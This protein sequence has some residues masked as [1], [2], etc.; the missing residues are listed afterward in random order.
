MEGDE[1]SR[2]KLLLN[3]EV[4]QGGTDLLVIAVLTRIDM[5][6]VF[7]TMN[8]CA[9]DGIGRLRQY[10]ERMWHA[11]RYR[12]LGGKGVSLGETQW[13]MCSQWDS[14]NE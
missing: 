7:A 9:L 12:R 1:T 11:L 10:L 13:P 6:K 2:C 8:Q 5:Y 3:K 14:D 4:F